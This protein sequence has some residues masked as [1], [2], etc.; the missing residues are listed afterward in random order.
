M[1]RLWQI[2]MIEQAGEDGRLI[3]RLE[4]VNH[5]ARCLAGKGCGAGVF[6]RWFTRGDVELPVPPASGLTAGQRVRVGIEALDLV[7][8]ATW[9]YAL[10]VVAFAVATV[11]GHRLAEGPPLQDAL[12]LLLGLSA[13][14]TMF[15]LT[16]GRR[17]Q[18]ADMHPAIEPAAC[19]ALES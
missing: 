17:R 14:A 11:I 3:V 9:L 2:G 10:P 19:P 18:L 7:R 16:A 1:A 5:C 4:A 8:A 12:A 6:S 15:A 13:G